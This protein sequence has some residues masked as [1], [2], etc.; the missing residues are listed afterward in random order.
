MKDFK[1]IIISAVL[2]DVIVSSFIQNRFYFGQLATIKDTAFPCANF[3]ISGGELIQ[4]IPE[5]QNLP[6]SLWA[7]SGNSNDEVLDIYSAIFDVINNECKSNDIDNKF[8]ITGEIARPIFNY[9][10]DEEV[11]YCMGRWEGYILKSNS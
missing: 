3:D 11:Y 6:F 9:D 5:F 2:K 8:V 7:W 10:K 4:R 1:N